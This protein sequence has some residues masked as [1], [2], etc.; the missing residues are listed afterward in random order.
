MT[1]NYV[2][3]STTHKTVEKNNLN[4]DIIEITKDTMD[5]GLYACHEELGVGGQGKTPQ[6][7]VMDIL[8]RHGCE[9]IEIKEIVLDET[10]KA[11]IKEIN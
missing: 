9:N 11:W 8:K 1:N 6:A 2:I 3:V 10:M 4:N 7:V 5:R